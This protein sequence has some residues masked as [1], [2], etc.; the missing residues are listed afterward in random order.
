VDQIRPETISALSHPG[1]PYV[2]LY[3]QPAT[4]CPHRRLDSNETAGRIHL[5]EA[6]SYR[7]A[8]ERLTA[9]A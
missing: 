6:I 7:I 4:T 9:A 3:L 5:A 8:G 2:V 1:T